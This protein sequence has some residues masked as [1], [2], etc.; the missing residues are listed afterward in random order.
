MVAVIDVCRCVYDGGKC[1]ATRLARMSVN[2]EAEVRLRLRK[3]SWTLPACP[4]PL[5][6]TG[7]H[8]ESLGAYLKA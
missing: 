8:W 1:D 7:N 4:V 5:G 3:V 6:I 2:A